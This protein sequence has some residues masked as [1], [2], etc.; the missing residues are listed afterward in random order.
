MRR[1]QVVGL[2]GPIAGGK[3]VAAELFRKEL[4]FVY[5]SLSDRVREAAKA[6]GLKDAKREELQNIGDEYRKNFGKSAF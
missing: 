5:F 3:S 2:T 6:R 1:A 4:G